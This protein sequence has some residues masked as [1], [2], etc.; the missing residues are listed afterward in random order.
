MF[1]RSLRNRHIGY[2]NVITLE[3]FTHFYTVYA[4]I[5]A[6]DLEANTAR[7]K[8]PYEVNLPN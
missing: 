6:A 1:V 4:K 8:L 3:L 7:L 5:S 2:V